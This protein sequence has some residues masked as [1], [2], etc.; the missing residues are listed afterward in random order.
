MSKDPFEAEETAT[1]MQDRRDGSGLKS[2]FGNG[3]R[4]RRGERR[5]GGR[6]GLR[7]GGERTDDPL[8]PP[9]S[10]AARSGVINAPTG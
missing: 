8:V 7:M 10:F 1:Q 9:S 4:E 6:K 2:G 3:S 5:G